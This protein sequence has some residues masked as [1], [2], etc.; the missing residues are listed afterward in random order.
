MFFFFLSS[1]DTVRYFNRLSK[2]NYPCISVMNP[3]WPCPIIFNILFN[4][5][6]CYHAC[7]S[8]HILYTRTHTVTHT[9]IPHFS[10][11]HVIPLC[12]YEHVHQPLVFGN[13]KKSKENF[14]FYKERQKAKIAFSVCFA[15]SHYGG[16]ARPEHR[17][18]SG[19]IEL[20]PQEIHSTSQYPVARALN[21]VCEHLCFVL[22]YSVHPLARCVLRYQKSLK[23][24]ILGGSR[25]AQTFFH[26][27]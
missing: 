9:G 10:E 20:L 2:S 14:C 6:Q 23:E 27:S 24:V 19:P 16:S 11:V 13:W 18:K 8:L 12:S 15:M 21:C 3:S 17:G 1:T 25:N 26:I 22:I 7:S 4:R 5:E